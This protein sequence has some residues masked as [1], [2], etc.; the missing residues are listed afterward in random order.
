MYSLFMGELFRINNKIKI[1]IWPKDHNP[2]HVHV[3]VRSEGIEFRVFL[4]DLSVEPIT[5]EQLS[6]RD[7]KMVIAFIKNNLDYI[8][9]A[10]NEI[11][12]D[13]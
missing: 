9:E 4:S 7:E 2:A 13:Q 3:I 6:S 12:K 1:I 8:R 5:A 11:Q 10:W